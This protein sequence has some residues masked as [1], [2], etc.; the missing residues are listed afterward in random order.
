MELKQKG[1]E[2]GLIEE[3][4]GGTERNDRDE[5]KKIIA[6]KR[7]KYDEEKLIRYLVG[8]GFGYWEVKEAIE[9]ESN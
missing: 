6:K 2:G 1:V 3:V 8:Q 7:T 9:E 5:M 4:M